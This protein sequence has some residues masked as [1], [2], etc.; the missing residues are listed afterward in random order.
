MTK[1]RA[2]HHGD[3]RRTLMSEALGLIDERGLDGWTLKEAARRAGVSHTAP[4]RHFDDKDALLEALALEGLDAVRDAMLRAAERA[5]REDAS[6]AR[7]ALLDVAFSVVRLALN[8]PALY[9]VTF[10]GA[11]PNSIA[12]LDAAAETT[13]FGTLRTMVER[14]QHAGLLD[15]E[16]TPRDLALALWATTHG[17]AAL[18]A[19]GRLDIPKRKQRELSDQL[20]GALVDGIGR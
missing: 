6:D 2:Y 13:A 14:W 4:Y 5:E 15:A 9:Q 18:L 1:K 3:L 16:A 8:K 7:R 17:L 19:T 11:R 10:S 12:Q 20:V